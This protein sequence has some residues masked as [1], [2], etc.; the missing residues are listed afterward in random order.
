M[1]TALRWT[2]TRIVVNCSNQGLEIILKLVLVQPGDHVKVGVTALD[3]W[4]FIGMELKSQIASTAPWK[5]PKFHLHPLSGY[6]S[7]SCPSPPPHKGSWCVKE[8]FFCG[9]L[10]YNSFQTWKR[11]GLTEPT[12]NNQSTGERSSHNGNTSTPKIHRQ[13]LAEERSGLNTGFNSGAG[14]RDS[15][16]VISQPLWLF[17]CINPWSCPRRYL[18]ML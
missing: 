1:L 14:S 17:L 4:I 5:N 6:S 12:K 7:S 15:L 8:F 13:L 2:F 9:H 10:K 16:K 3:H 18:S 11:P